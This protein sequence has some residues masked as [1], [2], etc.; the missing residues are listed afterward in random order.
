MES[1][2]VLK[3]SLVYLTCVV[4][5]ALWWGRKAEKPSSDFYGLACFWLVLHGSTEIGILST[6][7]LTGGLT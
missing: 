1:D 7:S 2:A 3:H 6:F 4:L 5:A